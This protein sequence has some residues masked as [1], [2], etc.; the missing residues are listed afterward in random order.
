MK[1][2]NGNVR[3]RKEGGEE[4]RGLGHVRARARKRDFADVAL[5][6][7]ESRRDLRIEERHEERDTQ[8]ARREERREDRGEGAGRR[9]S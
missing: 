4:R 8:R 7:D 1:G 3:R 9:V 2:L 5:S 6:A